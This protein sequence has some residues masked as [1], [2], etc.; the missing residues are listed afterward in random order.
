MQTVWG[1]KNEKKIDKDLEQTTPN[2]ASPYRLTEPAVY[3][4]EN[5]KP[6][7][8]LERPLP[9]RNPKPTDKGDAL[10]LAQSET[11]IVSLSCKVRNF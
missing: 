1:P 5:T 3:E 11:V 7:S 10:K 6:A 9:V 2:A 8:S 4:P